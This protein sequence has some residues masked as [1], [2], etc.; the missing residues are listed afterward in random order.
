MTPEDRWEERAGYSPFTLAVEIAALLTA[1]AFAEG[2][3]EAGAARYLRETADDWN[4]SVERWTY[5]AGT[6]LAE[7]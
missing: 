1:A 2:R 6:G 7:G 4:G 3:G 5:V